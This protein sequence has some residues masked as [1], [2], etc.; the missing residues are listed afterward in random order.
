[1]RTHFPELEAK[2]PAHPFAAHWE[3]TLDDLLK[4]SI[5][6]QLM[7]R[8]GVTEPALRWLARRIGERCGSASE[9]G[10]TA[11]TRTR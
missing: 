5:V 3:P 4:E 8:D 9:R 1:M 2:A 7:A 6:Q 11:P 10:E